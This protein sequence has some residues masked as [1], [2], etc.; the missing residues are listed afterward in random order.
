MYYPRGNNFPMVLPSV[1]FLVFINFHLYRNEII[2]IK[3][4]WI[5]VH[6]T[7]MIYKYAIVMVFG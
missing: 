1:F 3:D 6:I 5:K 2:S 4:H 7:P